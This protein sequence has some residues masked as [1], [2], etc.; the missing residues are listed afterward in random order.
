MCI[1]FSTISN[2]STEFI[3]YK[4]VYYLLIFVL[5]LY[6]VIYILRFVL[7]ALVHVK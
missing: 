7:M 2:I 5:N 3:I 4:Q 1:W 6:I